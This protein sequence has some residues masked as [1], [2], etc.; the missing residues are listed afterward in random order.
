M[1]NI[2]IEKYNELHNAKLNNNYC[3]HICNVRCG[4]G[5]IKEFKVKDTD[6]T[7]KMKCVQ[8]GGMW[9]GSNCFIMC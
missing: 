1:A 6:L 9:S 7:I 8:S 2:S 4:L 3:N 5:K